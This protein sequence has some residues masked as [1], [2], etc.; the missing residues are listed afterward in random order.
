[1]AATALLVLLSAPLKCSVHRPLLRVIFKV[2]ERFCAMLEDKAARRE[3]VRAS[4][5]FGEEREDFLKPFC[6]ADER[7]WPSVFRDRCGC[8]L[9]QLSSP[10]LCSKVLVE[11]WAGNN[12]QVCAPHV[13]GVESVSRRHRD[14]TSAH[15]CR[16]VTAVPTDLGPPS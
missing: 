6:P 11:S 2:G 4:D 12:P 7:L 5:S 15:G 9:R 10:P 14:R 1:M 16:F 13:I 3:V 8:L